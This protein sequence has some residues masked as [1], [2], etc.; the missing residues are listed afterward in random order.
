M[1]ETIEKSTF[2]EIR[3]SRAREE[4]L[5]QI[6]VAIDDLRTAIWSSIYDED[7]S[8]K[9]TESLTQFGGFMTTWL[10]N[11]KEAES[12]PEAVLAKSS[13]AAGPDT[14]TSTVQILKSEEELRI[15][16]GVVMEPGV[17]D[18]HGDV[19]DE[20]EVRKAFYGF[21]TAS[22]QF[23]IQHSNPIEGTSRVVESF[24]A[25]ADMHIGG[26]VVRK[27][28]WVM[29]LQVPEEI[30]PRVKDGSLTGFS[31]GGTAEIEEL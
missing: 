11:T 21:M 8:A 18:S 6:E 13:A 5:G 10:E 26:E 24:L 1:T 15:V 12:D 31:I 28:A 16:T 9:I 2:N 4:M 17:E 3:A 7:P 25:P 19:T 27:G 22:P 30:W 29:G 14:F 20:D 23:G